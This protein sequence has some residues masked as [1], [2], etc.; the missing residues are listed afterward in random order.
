MELVLRFPIGR[1]PPLQQISVENCTGKEITTGLQGM[2]QTRLAHNHSLLGYGHP[3]AYWQQ[4]KRLWMPMV[5]TKKLREK[6]IRMR[7]PMS[8]GR[9]GRGGRDGG[10]GGRGGGRGGGRSFGGRGGRGGGMRDEGP[11]D[12]VVGALR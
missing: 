6:S 3:R 1:G 4:R 5:P 2:S 7:A 12:E 11:P 10:R 9:G 8:M